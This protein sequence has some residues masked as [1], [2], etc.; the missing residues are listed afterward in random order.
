MRVPHGEAMHVVYGNCPACAGTGVVDWN[1]IVEVLLSDWREMRR[2]IREQEEEDDRKMREE[3]ARQEEE[4][5]KKNE[6]AAQRWRDQLELYR[7]ED[8][9]TQYER[10]CEMAKLKRELAERE[11]EERW[12]E[13]MKL[14]GPVHPSR[15][16]PQ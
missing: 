1:D 6:A 10:N 7:S 14:Y 9:R 13:T 12:R 11:F 2:S 3:W 4:D 8:R 16:H 15:N 5:K